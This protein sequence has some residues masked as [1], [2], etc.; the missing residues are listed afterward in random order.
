[1][2]AV[3]FLEWRQ[4][5]LT[6]LQS[7]HWKSFQQVATALSSTSLVQLAFTHLCNNFYLLFFID[8]LVSSEQQNPRPHRVYGLVSFGVKHGSPEFNVALSCLYCFK[9][10]SDPSSPSLPAQ[11]VLDKDTLRQCKVF[12]RHTPASTNF[13]LLPGTG[14]LTWFVF[15]EGLFHPSRVEGMFF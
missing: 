14:Q 10:P 11:P 7:S 4:E 2:C 1:M 9:L 3:A 13:L 15:L 8:S 6:G 12:H 5:G